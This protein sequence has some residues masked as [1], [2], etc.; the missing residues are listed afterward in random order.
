LSL[1]GALRGI[2]GT[3][4]M[5]ISARQAGYERLFISKDNAK[6]ASYIKGLSVFAVKDLEEIAAH[7]DGRITITPCDTA[8]FEP[9]TGDICKNDMAYVKG[10]QHAKRALEIAAAGGHNLLFV[11]PPGSG[12]TMLARAVPGILPDLS[13]EEAL[14]ISKIQSVC[15]QNMDGVA[16]ARP[17]R[18]PHHTLSTAALTGGGHRVMPGEIS[19]AHGGVLFLDELAEFKRDA[20]EALRQPLEDRRISIARANVKVTYPANV[21]LIASMNPCPC[22]N[23]G[24]REKQCRCTPREIN[25]YLSRISGPL[26]D[27]IDMHIGMEEIS[28]AELMGERTGETSKEIRRRV[29]KARAVQR[30][31]YQQS[32]IFSNAALSGQMI[33]EYCRLTGECEKL[34]ES[35][36]H[37]FALSARAMT[38][39]LKVSRTIADLDGAENIDKKHLAEAIQYRTDL[40]YWG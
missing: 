30:E 37:A 20:L 4:P 39:V 17:F 2:A 23:F 18:S 32:G 3:L 35:A 8:V 6:E 1:D 14:E 13:F 33:D 22:G 31:R 27:R 5:A 34:L 11:G 9:D 40:K 36:Y 25:R 28:Y 10:Q 29:N 19:L 38:R 7:L 24:S 21:I 12:K 15:G 26:L 16:T